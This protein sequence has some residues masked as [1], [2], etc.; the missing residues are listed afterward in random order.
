MRVGPAISFVPPALDAAG[1]TVVFGASVDPQGRV[2]ST[3]DLY[4]AAP[5]G[6]GL[7]RLTNYGAGNETVPQGITEVSL[8]KTGAQ[9]A[10]VALLPA[11]GGG[12][13]QLHVID[14]ASGNDR[15][16]A[17]GTQGCIL[18]LAPTATF[19]SC[20][21]SPHFTPDGKRILFSVNR[22][23]PFMIVN[24]DGTGLASLPI[25]TGGLAPGPQRVIS[26]NG[27]FVFTSAAP[28]GPTFAASATDVYVANLDGTG[29]RNLTKFGNNSQI[30]SRDAT[31]SDDGKT[32]V[33]ETNAAGNGLGTSA[34]QIW[35][36]QSDGTGLRQL[37]SG[38]E[39][40]L[41]PSISADGTKVAFVQS[42]QINVLRLDKNPAIPV[43]QFQFSVTERPVISDDASLIAF[44]AGPAAG[45]A[46]AI[47]SVKSD[48]T[49]LHQVYAPRAI[50]P[51]GVAS[52]VLGFPPS[53]GSLITIFGTNLNGD[54]ITSARSFPLPDGLAG[55]RV[56]VNGRPIPM[57]SVT[58]WQINA[59]AP[60]DLPAG[61]VNV[62]LGFSDGSFS[63]PDV[64]N[65]LNSA[66]VPF[67]QFRK[68]ADGRNGYWQIA[69][70]HA[71]TGT[72]ADD[73]HP[74]AAREVLEIFGVGFGP[75]NPAVPGG[76]AS[77]ASPPAR[78]RIFPEVHIGGE[79][80]R[81]LF[82]G[83]APGLAG[84]YQVNI[85]VPERLKQGRQPVVLQSRQFRFA[86][87]GTITIR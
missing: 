55:V 70:F 58:P 80:A 50:S 7:R 4:L 53:R 48:G 23:Q 16:I 68:S 43:T 40:S 38:S 21:H 56:L 26:R 86:G 87:P 10:V 79:R 81:V 15:P 42:G 12:P 9:A 30:F 77:P 61:T 37:T 74:A 8:S 52:P 31:I 34:D 6:S 22:N 28:S 41:Q 75:T 54:Q 59:Q 11:R 46:G 27:L 76:M 65:I 13:G 2:T 83:L 67:T 49:N 20:L 33:F 24:S 82:A 72:L 17:V 45:Q 73:E 3:A 63:P 36:V 14:T 60:Q 18:P 1:R 66:P 85:V 84:V 44:T 71:G 62:Q 69:A 39:P 5:D 32:V 57:V 29:L 78:A 64:V 51:N 25:F 19:F 47:D 35:T